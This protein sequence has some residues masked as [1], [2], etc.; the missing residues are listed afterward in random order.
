MKLHPLYV[1]SG[2]GN[3]PTALA[4]F[5]AALFDAGVA[6]QNL[7]HLSSVIP[8]FSRPV[9]KKIE[10]DE[11]IGEYGNQ[12][13]CVYAAKTETERGKSAWAGLGWA[14][15]TDK[16]PRGLFVEHV[17][18]NEK[19][20]VEQINLTLDSMTSYRKERYGPV[21]CKT[22]GI[23]CENDPVCAIV[24]AVYISVPWRFKKL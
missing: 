18:E 15:T 21:K 22:I 6:N 2:T 24:L 16:T 23:H 10:Q 4:A 13:Y 20:V 17:G 19:N 8:P 9:V 1:T 5:D 7:I 3:G 14:M 11:T 12:L